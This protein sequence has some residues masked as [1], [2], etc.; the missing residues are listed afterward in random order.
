VDLVGGVSGRWIRRRSSMR[1]DGAERTG[2][3]DRGKRGAAQDHRANRL[4]YPWPSWPRRP[5]NTVL[6]TDVETWGQSWTPMRAN[7]PYGLV[8][9]PATDRPGPASPA[10]KRKFGDAWIGSLRRSRQARRSPAALPRY[11][12]HQGVTRVKELAVRRLEV[13]APHCLCVVKAE[14]AGTVPTRVPVGSPTFSTV[15][16]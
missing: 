9:W 13:L 11:V 4:P 2:G 5:A 1:S 8:R 12:G 7:A 15:D 14:L 3:P 16:K 10:E 6:T